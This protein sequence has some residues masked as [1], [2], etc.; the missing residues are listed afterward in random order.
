MSLKASKALWVTYP[1]AAEPTGITPVQNGRGESESVMGKG[2]KNRE[3]G[4]RIKARLYAT[5]LP[6]RFISAIKT[7]LM[8]IT[9]GNWSGRGR[10]WGRG[11]CIH[12][13]CSVLHFKSH[14]NPSL[15]R[16]WADLCLKFCH[17][18]SSE[19]ELEK[20]S[21]QKTLT[22]SV[23]LPM[24]HSLFRPPKLLCRVTEITLCLF[25]HNIMSA[26]PFTHTC[27]M[28]K[29]KRKF[30]LNTQAIIYLFITQ[31]PESYCSTWTKLRKIWFFWR[32]KSLQRT[33]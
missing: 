24:T 5:V 9:S 11:F 33:I 10:G 17:W 27:N 4:S 29:N 1:E 14:P 23:I 7:R 6:T 20:W 2:R 26:A 3:E 31:M 32:K 25:S 8:K 18:A 21:A 30:S 16:I 28:S 22:K 13:L 15:H 12:D 19:N